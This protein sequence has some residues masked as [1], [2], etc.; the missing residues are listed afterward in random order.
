MQTPQKFHL[1]AQVL[2]SVLFKEHFTGQQ[3]SLSSSRLGGNP[4]L[5]T[6]RQVKRYL[7]I[8]YY[9]WEFLSDN[10]FE[11]LLLELETLWT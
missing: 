10:N 3:I 8:I 6:E 11:V 9:Y 2:N 4:Y 7:Q 5:K 1:L